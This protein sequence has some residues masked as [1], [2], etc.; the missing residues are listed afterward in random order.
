MSIFDNTAAFGLMTES[1]QEEMRNWEHGWLF[2]MGGEWGKLDKTNFGSSVTYRARPAPLTKD[3]IDWSHVANEFNFLS[4]DKGGQAFISQKR[5]YA[6]NRRWRGG[7]SFESAE[8]FASYVRGTCDWK[9]SLV[10]R[11]G[12]EEKK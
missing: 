9:D 8:T 7:F 5:P 10:V 1:E 12:Y 2:Y 11:P 3:S 6:D 4:R